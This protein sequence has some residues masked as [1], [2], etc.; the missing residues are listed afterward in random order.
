MDFVTN[1]E[2]TTLRFTAT[3][4]DVDA[5][6]KVWGTADVDLDVVLFGVQ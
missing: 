6:V 4:G 2:T 3:G 5:T 1:F